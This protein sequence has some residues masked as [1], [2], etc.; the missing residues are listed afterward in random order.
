MLDDSCSVEIL[1]TNMLVQLVDHLMPALLI[2]DT[3][4]FFS[5]FLCTYQRFTTPQQVLDLLFMK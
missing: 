2:R 1:K 5:M 3:F 4:F